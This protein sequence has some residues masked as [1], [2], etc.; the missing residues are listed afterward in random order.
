M[1][2]PTTEKSSEPLTAE[3]VVKALSY[4]GAFLKKHVLAALRT[5]PGITGVTE[6][7]PSDFGGKTRTSDILAGDENNI[8]YVIECKKV[9]PEKS[10]IFL[11][12]V[13][14]HYRVAR[15]C[16]FLGASSTFA[17][18]IPPET[19][20]CSEGYEYRRT[21]TRTS[22]MPA[23]KADQSP[24][25]E[26]GAQL[27]SAFLG[28]VHNR[29]NKKNQPQSDRTVVESYV[30]VLVTN[31]RLFFINADQV[32]LD[33][34]T[35]EVMSAPAL[36]EMPQVILKQPAASPTNFPDFRTSIV[37]EERNQRFH[38]SIYVI[39]AKS[40]GAFFAVEHRKFLATT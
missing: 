29:V 20:V 22:G 17:L 14:H 15:R 36:T 21:E 30:P 2:K 31:A 37:T 28:F 19:P 18:S 12:V 38:E 10:W 7:H 6:E 8:V 39:N 11:K 4:H 27:A 24:I 33:L 13:D 5:A 16:N 25:F 26:A 34:D 23:K 3:E 32:Q 35:G 40:L 1:S 9:S